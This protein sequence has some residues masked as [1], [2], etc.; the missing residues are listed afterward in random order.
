MD[1]QNNKS[2]GA[3]KR[4]AL[5]RFYFIEP[6]PNADAE[7]LALCLIEL[8]NVQEVYITEG[9]CGYIVKARFMNEK[10]PKDIVRYISNNINQKFGK[11]T[12]FVQYT[13]GDAHG[14]R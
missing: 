14:S 9:D 1:S 12:S 8:P 2:S 11:V 7:K 3:K 13:K 4:A 6:R 10:E 5:H